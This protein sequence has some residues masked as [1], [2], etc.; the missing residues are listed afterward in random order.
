MSKKVIHQITATMSVGDAISNEVLAIK[1]ILDAMGIEN[2]IYSEN[3]DSRLS[4]VVNDY[5]D[6]KGNKDDILINHFGI[7]SSVNDYVINLK[8]NIKIIRYHNITPKEFFI[9]YSISTQRLCELG[10]NQLIK[11]KGIYKYALADSEY[12]KEELIELGYENIKVIPIIMA[13]KDYEKTPDEVII[14]KYS[15]NTKNI[16]FVGRVSPNKKQEDVIRSFYYYK[17][18]FNK[19][20]RLF[21]VGNY[22]GMERY[23]GKLI[24]LT[25]TL[26]LKDVI[27][28]GHISF[29]SILAYYKIA[30]LFLCMSEHEG[31]CVPLVES[32]FFKV[33]ILAYN[34]C[35]IPYTLGGSSVLVNKKDYK[36]IASM[37]DYILENEEL[38]EKVISKQLVRL[39]ELRPKKVESQFKKYLS[40]I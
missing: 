29:E 35:A 11:S 34:S 33:P 13:L 9:G 25:K 16:V 19:D 10:R 28:T 20:A 2:K 31:F 8:N 3:I 7:G 26:N 40:E 36:Y 4:K 23:Y 15:D 14:N 1:K 18:Y 32:M 21:I 17:K 5:R 30:D 6:Y 27:F 37:M 12:N 22:T 24:D 39:D 38:K